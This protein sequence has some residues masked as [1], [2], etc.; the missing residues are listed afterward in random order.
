MHIEQPL[1]KTLIYFIKSWPTI[2]TLEPL[3]CEGNEFECGD[4]MCIIRQRV[5]D[6]IIDCEDAS[7][8]QNCGK[9]THNLRIET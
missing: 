4:G 5:C 7:D 3:V 6:G 8:E 2:A 9:M 1:K